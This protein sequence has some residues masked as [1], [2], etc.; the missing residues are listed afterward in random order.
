MK[1]FLLTI[2]LITILSSSLVAQIKNECRV[3]YLD[4]S[5][6]MI[7]NGIWDKVRDN[8]KNAIDNVTDETTDLYVIPF[9][10]YRKTHFPLPVYLQKAT[11][12][13]KRFLK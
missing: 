11:S 9:T 13:G 3:Y 1:K 8:L 5:Y 10:D 6:S 4:C 2:F 12:E 7:T